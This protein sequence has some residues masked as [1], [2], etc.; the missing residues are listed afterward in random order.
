[1]TAKTLLS[2]GENLEE[3]QAEYLAI[4]EGYR[5]SFQPQNYFEEGLIEAMAKVQFKLRRFDA[6]EAAS[7]RPRSDLFRLESE[8]VEI[9]RPGQFLLALKYRGALESQFYRAL[10][11][12]QQARSHKQIQ[13]FLPEAGSDGAA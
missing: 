10:S 7:F 5:A 11:A 12:L 6:L 4:V 13:L 8:E 9:A 3:S 2:R 1:M